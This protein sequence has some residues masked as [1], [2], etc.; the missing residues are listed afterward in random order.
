M[1]T[2]GRRPP[3]FQG[4]V[5]ADL[6]LLDGRYQRRSLLPGQALALGAIRGGLPCR[7]PHPRLHAALLVDG[8]G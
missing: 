2:S 8:D 5:T 3:A 4:N 6:A 7:G 1:A